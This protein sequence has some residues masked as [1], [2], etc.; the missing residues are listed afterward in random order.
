[1]YP[2]FKEDIQAFSRILNLIAHFELGNVLLVNHQIRATYRYLSKIK[3]LDK[4]LRTIL[5]FVRRIP[6]I[7]EEDV[8]QEFI[9]L[10]DHL[11]TLEQDPFERRSFLY[12]DIISWLESKIENRPVG[13][14]IRDKLRASSTCPAKSPT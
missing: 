6:R 13:D 8:Q 5:N 1:I 3:Q 11:L 9:K 12:L 10:R 4:V 2:N 7:A 14:V